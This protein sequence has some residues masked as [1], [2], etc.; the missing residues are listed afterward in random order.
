MEDNWGEGLLKGYI[1][2]RVEEMRIG[3]LGGGG[4]AGRVKYKNDCKA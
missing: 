1:R 2:E 4:G 3:G